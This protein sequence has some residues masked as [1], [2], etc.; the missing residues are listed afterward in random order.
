MQLILLLFAR[1][2]EDIDSSLAEWAG[3]CYLR[4]DVQWNA[5]SY[6]SMQQVICTQAEVRLCQEIN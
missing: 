1:L 5:I 6:R 3:D 4:T 2:P